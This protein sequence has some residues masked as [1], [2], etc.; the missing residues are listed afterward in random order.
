MTRTISL[1]YGSVL[2]EIEHASCFREEHRLPFVAPVT[3]SITRC[4][5]KIWDYT[6]LK[7]DGTKALLYSSEADIMFFVRIFLKGE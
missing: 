1:S 3:E 5:S 4:C 2:K 7:S 6:S